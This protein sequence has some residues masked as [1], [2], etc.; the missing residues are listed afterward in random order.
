MPYPAVPADATSSR[1]PTSV[2]LVHDGAVDEFISTMLLVAM[3]GVTLEGVVVVNADCIAEPAMDAASKLQQFLGRPEVP[4]A[5]SRAR[6]WNPFPWPYREDCIKFGQIPSL[7]PYQSTVTWPPPSGEELLTRLLREAVAAKRRVT[8]L[9]TC[10]LTPLTDVVS[11]EPALLAGIEQ[12]IWMGGAIHVA[13][14]LDPTTISPAVANKCAEWN[15]FWDPFAVDAAF[16]MFDG[17][18][19]F[20]L[21]ITND[22]PLTPEFMAALQQQGQTYRWSQLAYEGYSLVSAEPFYD[23]WDVTATCLLTRP[24]LFAPPHSASL[25]IQTWGFDQG[26]ISS[27]SATAHHTPRRH[28]QELYLAFADKPGFYD[29]VLSVLRGPG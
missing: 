16:R 10:P 3:P 12:I 9:I 4:L 28:V 21:D 18:R 7:A 26:C 15:A 24:D 25:A 23:M 1:G 2:V 13:G 27:S 22:T 20:P 14:N 6:G 29:Y 19:V 5:L 17:M 8:V 11:A